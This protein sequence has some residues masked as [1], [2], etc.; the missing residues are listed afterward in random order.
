MDICAH[1]LCTHYICLFILLYVCTCI[2]IYMYV[3][4]HVFTRTIYIY[5]FLAIPQTVE[6]QPHATHACRH[7][8]RPHWRSGPWRFEPWS[9]WKIQ[10][11]HARCCRHGSRC[12]CSGHRLD[13]SRY[14]QF[15]GH[16]WNQWSGVGRG[17]STRPWPWLS[18][19]GYVMC[20]WMCLGLF[21]TL[22]VG[23]Y[24]YIHI[25][26]Y[27]NIHIYIHTYF[28]YFHMYICM[29]IHLNLYLGLLV[30]LQPC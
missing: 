11:W 3:C 23:M 10:K 24:K 8:K 13:L 9:Y 16:G 7:A 1:Y 22:Y 14:C 30:R 27:V 20:M 21:A 26:I 19:V 2:H 28:L 5:T 25:Y 29:Y 18:A 6:F 4:L 12:L 15:G 17:L